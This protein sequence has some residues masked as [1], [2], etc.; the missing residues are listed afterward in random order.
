M[1]RPSWEVADPYALAI[2][3]TIS[4]DER[5][6]WTGTASTS[7]LRRRFDELV[8]YLFRADVHPD[9]AVLSTGTCL[10][11]PPPF[12]LAAG[13]TVSITVDEI[14]TLQNPVVRGLPGS[15]FHA[16]VSGTALW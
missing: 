8:S 4:R 11:P 15:H 3:M 1:I 16:G 6:E 2:S 14:G 7:Q 12:T 9:G 5:V 13:H 10:V